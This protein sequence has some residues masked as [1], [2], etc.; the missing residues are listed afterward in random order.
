MEI[1]LDL[2]FIINFVL[3][4]FSVYTFLR[5]KH[6][7]IK[8]SSL[9][10]KALITFL[11]VLIV[12]V[13][14]MSVSLICIIVF[15]P[16][17][18]DYATIDEAISGFSPPLTEHK[19]IERINTDL[20]PTPIILADENREKLLVYSIE[21]KQWF[22]KTR[23]CVNRIFYLIDN[24]YIGGQKPVEL[25]D[26]NQAYDI[27]DFPNIWF[28]VIYPENRG[29]IRINGKTPDFHDINFNGTDYVFWYIEKDGEKAILSFE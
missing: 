17:G 3:V 21:T 19:I 29:R 14:L 11:F 5:L 18:N 6:K 27:D 8:F 16:Q 4:A 1:L 15:Y 23:Y 7:K 13:I 20:N 26:E 25:I 28:G 9:P 2:L 22:G 24:L 10:K 12:S